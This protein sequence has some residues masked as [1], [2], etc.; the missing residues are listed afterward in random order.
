MPSKP[1]SNPR[2]VETLRNY[3]FIATTVEHRFEARSKA[4]EHKYHNPR[5]D[6]F[7]IFDI[8][9]GRADY[10]VLA[11]QATDAQSPSKHIEKM[12]KAPE[13]KQWLQVARCQI[14]HWEKVIKGTERLVYRPIV[15]EAK[16]VDATINFI[17]LPYEEWLETMESYGR[18]IS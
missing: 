6:V 11:V 15:L 3:G 12:L 16:V 4:W 18:P 8:L 10:G 7:G 14:W 9:A 5:R 17:P 2:T 13:L 1:Q